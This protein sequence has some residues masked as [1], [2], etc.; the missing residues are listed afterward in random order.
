MF[1]LGEEERAPWEELPLLPTGSADSQVSTSQTIKRKGC[2][3]QA[4]NTG[5]WGPTEG[6][7]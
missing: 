7:S 4:V 2:P 3:C 1:V 6:M 5:E